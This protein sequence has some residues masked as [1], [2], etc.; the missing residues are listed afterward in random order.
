MAREPGDRII[1]KLIPVI[2]DTID[3][4]GAGIADFY[5]PLVDKMLEQDDETL[6]PEVRTLLEQAKSGEHQEQ[7]IAGLLMGGVSG[8]LS[9]LLNNELAPLIYPI[10][11]RNPY[12]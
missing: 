6:S 11:G 9:T 1:P 10:V 8:A 12:I 5:R 7:A 4:L 3:A 2:R